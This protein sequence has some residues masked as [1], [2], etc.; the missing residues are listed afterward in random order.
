MFYAIGDVHGQNAQLDRALGLIAA[1]GGAD[2][3]LY[4]VGDLV[5]RGPDSRGVI[6][7]IIDAQTAGK[8]W[9]CTLG[10]HD[11]MFLQFVRTGKV[12]HVE[13]QS[14]KSWL[15]QRLGG[16]MTL[17]SYMY[18]T[19]LDHPEWISWNDAKENGLDPAS[20]SLLQALCDAAKKAVP[21]AH[22][23]W[24]ADRPL[25]VK[26][27]HDHVFVHAGIRP[28]IAL[29]DQ[30]QSDLVWIRDGWLDYH[31]ALDFMYVHGHTALDFPKHH[32]NRINIDGGAGYGRPLVPCVCDGSDWFT[33]DETGRTALRP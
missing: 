12:N 7:R 27:P 23:D 18:E 20:S 25:Y 24:I 26:A 11:L 9:H 6:Q 32:R 8:S 28:G 30:S 5:D 16:C 15:N 31:G 10:N 1:D 21:A 4:F 33:L 17:A 22:L 19:E 13:I 3:P 2:A 14:H 29:S